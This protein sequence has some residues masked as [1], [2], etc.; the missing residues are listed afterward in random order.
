MA[1]GSYVHIVPCS[2]SDSNHP[3]SD[4]PCESPVDNK[5]TNRNYVSIINDS[6]ESEYLKPSCAVS[7]AWLTC[8]KENVS[9]YKNGG[10][11][12]N[13]HTPDDTG[14]YVGPDRD[15]SG[16]EYLHTQSPDR[17]KSG[18]E[19][20]HTQSPDRDTSGGEYLH[21]QLPDRGISGGECL[22]TQSPDQDI[23][24]ADYLHTRVLET[25][26][27]DVNAQADSSCGDY[28]YPEHQGRQPDDILPIPVG[29]CVD[30]M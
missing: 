17:G 19:Y 16:G 3:I 9:D 11:L 10:I 12:R 6:D 8:T 27:R 20:L 7:Q 5:S 29:L 21:T 2:N 28:V 18:G 23:S 30:L 25:K 26:T 13:H 1:D 22:H 24:N 4:K 14:V 15:T